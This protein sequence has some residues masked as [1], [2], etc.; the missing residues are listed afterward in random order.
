MNRVEG[1]YENSSLFHSN[2]ML[3][4]WNLC[5]RYTD[6]HI[7]AL[8]LEKLCLLGTSVA[9]A[10]LICTIM[11]FQ[12]FLKPGLDFILEINITTVQP[13]EHIPILFIQE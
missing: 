12:L 8:L 6:Q 4:C 13:L 11:L 3:Q 1:L 5:S 7:P 10:I 9:G 2:S